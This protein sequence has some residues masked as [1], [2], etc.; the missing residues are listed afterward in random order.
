MS[1]ESVKTQIECRIV[2]L[3]EAA[4]GN[5]VPTKDFGLTVGSLRTHVCNLRNKGFGIETIVG[6]GYRIST[7]TPEPEPNLLNEVFV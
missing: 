1:L 3:L 7:S 2:G 6:V 5:T 4:D